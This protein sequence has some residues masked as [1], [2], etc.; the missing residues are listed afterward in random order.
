MVLPAV[1]TAGAGGAHVACSAWA[2]LMGQPSCR[3][4]SG[5]THPWLPAQLLPL[6]STSPSLTLRLHPRNLFHPPLPPRMVG[7][8]AKEEGCGPLAKTS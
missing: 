7:N 5:L 8:L 3:A 4:G 6:G 1:P 2:C